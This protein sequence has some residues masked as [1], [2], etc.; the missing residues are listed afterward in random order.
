MNQLPI[1]NPNGA[2]HVRHKYPNM[3]ITLPVDMPRGTVINL[4]QEVDDHPVAVF[5]VPDDITQ[6]RLFRLPIYPADSRELTSDPT[7]GHSRSPK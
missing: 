4:F 5:P 1:T 6:A 7:P 2:P 3:F